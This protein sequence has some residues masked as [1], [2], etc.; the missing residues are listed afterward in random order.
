[1]TPLGMMDKEE[2]LEIA[3]VRVVSQQNKISALEKELERLREVVNTV[4]AYAENAMYSIDDPAAIKVLDA[5]R[6]KTGPFLT[7]ESE[8]ADDE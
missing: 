8:E 2:L 5:I 3:R 4:F 1:M 7:E 6:N